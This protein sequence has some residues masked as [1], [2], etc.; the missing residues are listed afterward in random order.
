MSYTVI[1]GI[2]HKKRAIRTNTDSMRSGQRPKSCRSTITAKTRPAAAGHGVD[3]LGF[4]INATDHLILRVDN[5][6]SLLVVNGDTL[7]AIKRCQ[8]CGTVVTT[9]SFAAATCD[10]FEPARD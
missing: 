3:L 7:R 2:S 5:K 8:L 4:C 1:F 6:H 10:V 9:V